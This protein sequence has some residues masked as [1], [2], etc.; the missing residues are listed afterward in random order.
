MQTF[1]TQAA[2]EA[3]ARPKW[4]GVEM[5]FFKTRSRARDSATDAKRIGYVMT[6]LS[7]AIDSTHKELNGLRARLEEQRDQLSALVGTVDASY[8]GREPHEEGQ[9]LEVESAFVAAARRTKILTNQLSALQL[10]RDSLRE[11]LG[12]T[13]MNS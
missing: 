13:E 1:D 7:Q 4:S 5:P 9:L 10:A 3:R 12:V 2:A 8:E 6:A 11:K